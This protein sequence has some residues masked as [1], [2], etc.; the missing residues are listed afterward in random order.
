[1]RKLT[2]S[3]FAQATDVKPTHQPEVG[4]DAQ[5]V[6]MARLTLSSYERDSYFQVSREVGDGAL[7]DEEAATALAYFLNDDPGYDLEAIDVFR[8]SGRDF[9]VHGFNRD[10]AY[11]MAGRLNIPAAIHV[12]TREEAYEFALRCNARPVKPLTN[13]DKWKRVRA[14]LTHFGFDVSNNEIARKCANAVTGAFVATVRARMD[15]EF[16]QTEVAAL[17][18]GDVMQMEAPV[19]EPAFKT[20]TRNGTTFK[21]A[22]KKIGKKAHQT[23]SELLDSDL[24]PTTFVETPADKPEVRMTFTLSLIAVQILRDAVNMEKLAGDDPAITEVRRALNL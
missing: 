17:A 3:K 18:A 16:K 12:G 19:T 7:H 21:M 5:S 10:A 8:I 2:V 20:V 1:M 9:L 6:I 22:V 15:D 11:R 13:A 23:S 4:V 14:A 24:P